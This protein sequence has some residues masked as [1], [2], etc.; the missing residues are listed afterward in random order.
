MPKWWMS[1]RRNKV[2]WINRNR[3]ACWHKENQ[4]NCREPNAPQ[5]CL[6]YAHGLGTVPVHKANAA[7]VTRQRHPCVKTTFFGTSANSWAPGTHTRGELNSKKGEG[8]LFEQSETTSFGARYDNA[9][10]RETWTDFKLGTHTRHKYAPVFFVSAKVICGA[11]DFFPPWVKIQSCWFTVRLDDRCLALLQ[12]RQRRWTIFQFRAGPR[13][14]RAGR[15][16]TLPS[17]SATCTSL[18]AT[19]VAL[20]AVWAH[21]RWSVRRLRCTPVI[22][23]AKRP[24]R[25]HKVLADTERD[26]AATT[27]ATCRSISHRRA[28]I[29]N[30]TDGSVFRPWHTRCNGCTLTHVFRMLLKYQSHAF[31]GHRTTHGP[32]HGPLAITHGEVWDPK[33]G[34]K[35]NYSEGLKRRAHWRSH[36]AQAST[37]WSVTR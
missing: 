20:S 32:P 30:N 26:G 34:V 1:L 9:K 15:R 22:I 29:E 24:S 8:K 4:P 10:Q 12:C 7:D 23:I 35:E 5:P 19:W 11:R 27:A 18:S 21:W 28:L 2:E 31:L 16:Q 14:T 37:R 33:T 6:S 3:K 17:F 25:E 13:E 36:T